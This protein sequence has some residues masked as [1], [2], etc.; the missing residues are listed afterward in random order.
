MNRQLMHP[1]DLL[2]MIMARIYKFGMTTTSGG[3]LSIKDENGDVWITP[4]AI[5]K[6]SLTARDI[7]CVKADG[8][9][10]GIH[11]PSSEYP[12]HLA[13]YK[14]RPDLKAVV[15]AHPPALVSFSI[16][17][18]I[19]DTKI[20]PQAHHV[21]GPVGYATYELPGSEALGKSIANIFSSGFNVVIMENH[22][23]VVGGEDIFTAYQ[24][25]ETLEFCARTII[26]ANSIGKVKFLSE[27]QALMMK[28]NDNM[29][30]EL[31]N[32]T[33]GTYEKELRQ[34]V[35]KVA[36]RAYEQR[37]IISTYG[38]FSARLSKDDF[39]ITPYGKDRYYLELEDIVLISNG[40]REPGKLPSRSVRLHH[41]IYQEHPDI[42]A[43]I[44]AQSPNATAYCVTGKKMDTRTI[45]ESY[46]L[47]RDIPLIPY[48]DQFQEG[49]EISQQVSKV[50]PILL[51][52]NDS[53]L[54]TGG[55]LLETF[56]RLEVA[57]FSA[58]SLTQSYHLG[59]LVPINEKEISD[60]KSKFNLEG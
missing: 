2:V 20:I 30:P 11:K 46:I 1:R 57:E 45:P 3:N 15:H 19:P 58:G 14:E 44:S 16:V 41:R 36:R 9:F 38:T 23:T 22:G 31:S 42:N 25:F 40:K 47:L 43:I 55:S 26:N 37:L 60:L 34:E 52:E 28:R 7:V 54:V 6:G 5:D 8:S 32:Y 53:M 35:V 50:A 56:D 59:D 48:G 29:L 33:S 10:E 39:L 18:K 4:S 51:L 49:R 24:R 21:C 27:E 12:F 17:R 13:I